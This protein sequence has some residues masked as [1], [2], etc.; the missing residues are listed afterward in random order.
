MRTHDRSEID[1][2]R[3]DRSEADGT[4]RAGYASPGVFSSLRTR[5]GSVPLSHRTPRPGGPARVFQRLAAIRSRTREIEAVSRNHHL[6]LH[7][8]D[9]GAHGAG[10]KDA[11]LG[12]IRRRQ[13]R[14]SDLEGWRLRSIL[15]RGIFIFPDKYVERKP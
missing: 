6:G 8:S 10:G 7:F 4:I 11:E 1:R 13:P 2:S 15:S 3:N 5:P 14:P 9:S 12:R